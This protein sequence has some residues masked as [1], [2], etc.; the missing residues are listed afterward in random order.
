M[1]TNADSPRTTRQGTILM[2]VP[3]RAGGAAQQPDE[4]P[5]PQN[6][7]IVRSS[8]LDTHVPVVRRVNDA[9]IKARFP[10]QRLTPIEGE[11]TFEKMQNL[12]KELAANALTAKVGFGGGKKGC[13]G[14]VYSNAKYRVE[15][16]TD[17]RVPET[18]GAFPT[19]PDNASDAEK[20]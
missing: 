4:P 8:A 17:W 15:A 5:P 20:K 10:H 11:P 14:V 13:L 12:E 1:S 3:D 19:F 7:I 18:Q 16:G 6:A 9:D 2:P